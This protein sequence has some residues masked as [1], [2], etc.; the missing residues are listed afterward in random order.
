M[1]YFNGADTMDPKS[2]AVIA[3]LG[4]AG[5]VTPLVVGALAGALVPRSMKWFSK[6]VPGKGTVH[7]TGG[8]TTTLQAV[9]TTLVSVK[10]ATIG[11]VIGAAIGWRSNLNVFVAIE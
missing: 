9:S 6:K 8:V 2:M 1:F 7:P 11:A 3:G 4:I 5:A 10:A